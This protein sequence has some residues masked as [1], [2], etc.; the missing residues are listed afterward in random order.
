[1]KWNRQSISGLSLAFS[2]ALLTSPLATLKVLANSTVEPSIAQMSP[3]PSPSPAP[4]PAPG[5]VPSPAPEAAPSPAPGAAPT[6]PAPSPAP[7][8][9]PSPTAPAPAPRAIIQGLTENTEYIAACR[10]TNTTVEVFSNSALT[11]AN[12]IGTFTP[13]TQVTLTGVLAPGRAQVYRQVAPDTIVVVGWVDAS[14]LTTCGSPSTKACYGVNTDLTVRT[15]PSVTATPRGTIPA[16]A[17]ALATTNPPTERTSPNTSPNFGRIWAEIVYLNGP[18][19]I[20][21]TGTYG[22]GNN[23]TR[24]PDAQCP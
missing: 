23:A 10:R 14:K 17:I 16:G 6:R 15:S 11:P 3:D 18:G 13:N 20:S 1:M 21:R 2:L 9:A 4:S 22:Q 24:L 5:A 8:T 19:W 7:R 12:R